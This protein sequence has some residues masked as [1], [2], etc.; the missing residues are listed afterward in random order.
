MRKTQVSISDEGKILPYFILKKVITEK[1]FF[2]PFCHKSMN[3]LVHFKVTFKLRY[4]NVEFFQR[5]ILLINEVS[6]LDILLHTTVLCR[7]ENSRSS[8][9]VVKG[10]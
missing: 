8:H 7:I 4:Q 3:K 10:N 1:L 5:N 2:T 9:A 6:P